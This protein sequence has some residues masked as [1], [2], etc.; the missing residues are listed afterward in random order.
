MSA[1][2]CGTIKKDGVRVTTDS[3]GQR[4]IEVDL[5]DGRTIKNNWDNKHDGKF[6]KR[7]AS[8]KGTT[9]AKKFVGQLGATFLLMSG[10][11]VFVNAKKNNKNWGERCTMYQAGEGVF[12]NDKTDI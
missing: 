5:D 7:L 9:K 6:D 8:A 12:K 1:T 10:L 4:T 2:G 3:S 11:S